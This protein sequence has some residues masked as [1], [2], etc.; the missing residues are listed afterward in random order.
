MENWTLIVATGLMALNGLQIPQALAAKTPSVSE[1]RRDLNEGDL[2]QARKKAQKALDKNHDNEEVQ[3]LMADIIDQEIARHKEVFQTNVPEELP[4]DAKEEETKT[5][6]ERARVLMDLKRYDEAVLATEKVFSYDP[7][8][9]AASRLMDQ[10]RERAFRDGKQELLVRH[11]MYK[12]ESKERVRMYLDQAAVSI[13]SKRWGAAR[14][15]TEKILLLEPDNKR[16]LKMH[17]YIQS[18]QYKPE[19]VR[20]AA[21]GAESGES[22]GTPGS[23]TVETKEPQS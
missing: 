13:K 3:K 22:A 7:G 4:K 21:G 6:L 12:S 23:E 18:H 9:L 10:I 8:N 5:W 19:P 11:Q 15:A 20:E 17:K 16:A 14:L 2:Y 1:I